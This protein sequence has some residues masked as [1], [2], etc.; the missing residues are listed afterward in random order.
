MI[1]VCYFQNMKFSFLTIISA[2]TVEV[3]SRKITMVVI[4]AESM[5]LDSMR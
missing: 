3:A 2:P 4:W 1:R 5:V